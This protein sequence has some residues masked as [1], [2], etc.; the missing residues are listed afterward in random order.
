MKSIVL[1][2]S[3]AFDYLMS[4][5]GRF[6]EHI[7]PEMIDK[8]SLSFLVDSL[9]R[10]P[11]GI[12]ANIAYTMALLDERPIIMAT[13]GEDFED[14]RRWLDSKGVDTSKVLVIPDE[15]TAS[16]F[17]TTDEVN[18]Q[19]ASFFPG[20]MAHAAQLSFNDVDP[21]PDLAV[22][23]PND[24]AVM[25]QYCLECTELGIPYLYDPSQQIIRLKKDELWNG[26]QKASLLF[27][28]EYELGLIKEKTG[29][30]EEEI[31][32]GLD[33]AVITRGEQGTDIFQP[34][35][36]LNVEAIPPAQIADP[37]GVGDAF[38]G[39][40]LKG[41]LNGLSLPICGRMGALSASYCLESYG[42]QGHDFSLPVFLERY[43][44]VFGDEAE[45]SSL[46]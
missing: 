9:V 45:L 21:K 12:A 2:G 11:G 30:A 39:G 46:A 35:G 40:F 8:I 20:A 10:R 1:T 33:F 17:V 26:I 32:G 28:N 22:I 4:F 27:C 29:R 7:L 5:P 18:A 19:I 6:S 23:S 34:S 13:V 24:P 3:I 37:T 14:Q 15:L 38:R 44:T 43:S 16:F 25:N 41:Y 36:V 42:P 31:F